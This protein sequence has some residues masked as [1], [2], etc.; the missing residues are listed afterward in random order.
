MADCCRAKPFFFP[1]QKWV[2]FSFTPRLWMHCSLLTKAVWKWLSVPFRD[3][4]NLCHD[5][6]TPKHTRAPT[7][8]CRSEPFTPALL[9]CKSLHK[10]QGRTELSSESRKSPSA[11]M[12]PLRITNYHLISTD[13]AFYC[14][15][16]FFSGLSTAFYHLSC[17]WLQLY[18]LLFPPHFF[19]SLS[20]RSLFL[21]PK[22]WL[23]AATSSSLAADIPQGSVAFSIVICN[24]SDSQTWHYSSLW[25]TVSW[26]LLTM[27]KHIILHW[28][29]LF[30]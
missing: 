9:R 6:P 10:V 19:P 11:E 22:Q 28:Q 4:S 26:L 17:T 7:L 14:F 16:I 25:Y 5:S 21:L 12:A 27:C 3:K 29:I 24:L 2:W 18:G 8:T 13:A 30:I 1:R 23:F 15:L 20:C